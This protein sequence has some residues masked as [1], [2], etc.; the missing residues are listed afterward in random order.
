MIFRVYGTPITQ[1]S[2]VVMRGHLVDVKS[3]ELKAWRNQ[4]ANTAKQHIAEPLEEAVAV[5]MCFIVRKPKTVTRLLPHVKPDAD[6]L[7]RACMDALTG[8]A[9][10]DDSQVTDLVIRKRY[11]ADNE[12]GVIVK[13]GEHG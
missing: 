5:E 2:K 8:V 4:I 1:G 10:V 9:Y 13:V 6:K 12:V 11:G 7:A 3:K